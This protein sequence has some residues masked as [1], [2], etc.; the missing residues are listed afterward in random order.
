MRL[1]PVASSSCERSTL[2]CLPTCSSIHMRAPPAPQHMPFVPLRP[3]ST[4]SIPP[5][6]PT[7]LRGRQ[8][9]V[10]VATEVARVVVHEP[11]FERRVRHV[12]LAFI[13]KNFEQLAVVHDLVVTAELGVF[14]GERV[15]AVRALRDDLSLHPWS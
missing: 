5:I 1:A 13:D 3:A 9:D 14:V 2:T 7:T 10:V 12:E 6:E 4:T 8:V 15:E 11:V